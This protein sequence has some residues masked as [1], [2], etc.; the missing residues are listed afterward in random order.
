MSIA[1]LSEHILGVVLCAEGQRCSVSQGSS[2]SQG[3][4]VAQGTG[5]SQGGS[6]AQGPC[7]NDSRL[8][9]RTSH[10]C[11]EDHLQQRGV[12]GVRLPSRRELCIHSSVL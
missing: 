6:V 4:G 3:A 1:G 5:V 9:K 12:R 2:V 8:G 11:A 10:D 7:G